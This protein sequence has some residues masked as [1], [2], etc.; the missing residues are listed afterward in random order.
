MSD[1]D[2]DSLSHTRR[3]DLESERHE[4]S[5]VKSTSL[6]ERGSNVS[7]NSVLFVQFEPSTKLGI[8]LSTRSAHQPTN[9]T[10]EV[11]YLLRYNT[12]RSQEEARSC[13]GRNF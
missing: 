12:I 1:T 8:S 10:Q 5:T 9:Y 7:S 3:L 4:K 13:K 6:R 2:T 11:V